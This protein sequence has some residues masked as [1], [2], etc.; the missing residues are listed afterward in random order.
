MRYALFCTYVAIEKMRRFLRPDGDTKLVKLR[1]SLE[2]NLR[3]V[4]NPRY[5]NDYYGCS[6]IDK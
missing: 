1:N 6:F 2:I 3:G 4:I 5:E